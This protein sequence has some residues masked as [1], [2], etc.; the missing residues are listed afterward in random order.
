MDS[1]RMTGDDSYQILVVDDEAEVRQLLKRILERLGHTVVTVDSA[2]QALQML[3]QFQAD[4]IISDISMAEMDGYELVRQLRSRPDTR[5][6]Y[7]IAMTGNGASSSEDA[8]LSAGFD[9]H[10]TKPFALDA[11]YKILIEPKTRRANNAF[12]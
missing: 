12:L 8:S 4:V 1:L 3:N 9:A 2:N 6:C 10:V 11:I 7:V 5:A